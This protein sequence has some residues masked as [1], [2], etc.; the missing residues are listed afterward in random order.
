VEYRRDGDRQLVA[1]L[2]VSSDDRI[3]G[4]TRSVAQVT[5]NTPLTLWPGEKVG[6]S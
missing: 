6:A 2:I 1:I 5:Q 4:S 3:R